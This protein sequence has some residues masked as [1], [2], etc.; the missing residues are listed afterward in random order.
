MLRSS[1][2]SL[3]LSV[4][5]VEERTDILERQITE[6]VSAHHEASEAYHQHSEEI[7]FLQAKMADL[8]DRSR[9]NI[10]KF[11]GISETVK[12]PDLIHHIQ[13][14]FLKL[15]P[16]LS[17]ADIAIDHAHRIAKPNHLP[18]TVQRDVLPRIHFFQTK[19][20]IMS[21]TSATLPDPYSSISL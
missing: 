9:R 21:A 16:Q 17:Q 13:Q 19:E 11:R 14:L 10:I 18:E 3:H 20:R 12:P 4:E 15:I 1:L 6:H 7:R 5:Q 2:S 8:E